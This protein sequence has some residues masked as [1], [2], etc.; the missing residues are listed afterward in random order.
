MS[1]RSS[2]A[3]PAWRILRGA[4]R[5][6]S[7]KRVAAAVGDGAQVVAAIHAYLADVPAPQA[8]AQAQIAQP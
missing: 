7:V 6:S 1:A 3:G 4:L 5:A 8:A 2:A